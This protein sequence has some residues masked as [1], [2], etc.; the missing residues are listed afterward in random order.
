MSEWFNSVPVETLRLWIGRA[1]HAAV[2]LIGAAILNFLLGALWR[3]LGHYSAELIRQRGGADHEFRKQTTTVADI[4][5]RTTLFVVWAVA[6]SLALREFNFDVAPL[7]AGAGV[8][9]IAV[10]FAAQNILRDWINGFFLLAEGNIRIQDVVRIGQL[11][12]T[13]ETLTLRTTTLRDY[14]G[15]VHVFSNGAIQSFSN[16]TIS[17]SC[18]VFEL[19]VE[20]EEEPA[21]LGAALS[22]VVDEIRAEPRWAALI[23]GPAEIAGLDRFTEQG[24]VIKARL[25]TRAGEQWQVGREVNRRLFDRCRLEGIRL[26]IARRSVVEMRRREEVPDDPHGS[27]AAG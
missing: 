7:L 21:R 20:P 2:Y 1:V 5:R 24:P 27:Q 12:G 25:R 16:L 11:S 19:A 13:V 6:I 4:L 22:A 10:G 23:P 8:A 3:R 17:H 9:G 14:D 18:A 15:A 26:A